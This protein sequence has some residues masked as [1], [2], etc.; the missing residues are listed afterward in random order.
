MVEGEEPRETQRPDT[1]DQES[2]KVAR[3]TEST[4]RAGEESAASAGGEE[5]AAAQRTSGSSQP[6]QTLPRP[7]FE[8]IVGVFSTQAF[9]ALGLLPNPVTGKT[10]KQ[11]PVARQLIDMLDVLEQKTQGNLTESEQRQL[12]QTLT[13]LR[14]AFV[15]A[16]RGTDEQTAPK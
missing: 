16:S 4:R 14:L 12:Q 1:T 7:T 8:S 5:R 10:E 6:Q 11:L 9:V 3:E 15:E 2:S 13:Y